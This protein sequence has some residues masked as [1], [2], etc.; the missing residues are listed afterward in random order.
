MDDIDDQ[1]FYDFLRNVGPRGV[2]AFA[3]WL[4]SFI[5][6]LCLP[7]EHPNSFL[8]SIGLGLLA[9]VNLGARIAA[10]AV[11]VVFVLNVLPPQVFS[12]IG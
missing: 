2:R 9:S 1:A 11:F 3:F 10:I 4:A 6:L 12:A 8:L 7:Y 5:L